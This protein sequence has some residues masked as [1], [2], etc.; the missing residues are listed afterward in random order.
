MLRFKPC[1][2]KSNSYRTAKINM[3]TLAATFLDNSCRS[4]PKHIIKQI[5]DLAPDLKTAHT[6]RRPHHGM[7]IGRIGSSLNHN[8][9][10][11]RG[12]TRHRTPPARMDCGDHASNRVAHHDR[13]TVGCIDT[14]HQAR[15]SSD[16]PVDSFKPLS[17]HRSRHTHDI[18][19]VCLT[20]DHKAILIHAKKVGKT[21]PAR[22]HMCRIIAGVMTCIELTVAA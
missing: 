1:I 21:F 16:Q 2:F 19:R 12:N 5:G 4:A 11:P 7:Y 15:L 13:H 3:R 22:S 9:N 6:Y 8:I 14:Q 20:R 10:C 17:R 18:G